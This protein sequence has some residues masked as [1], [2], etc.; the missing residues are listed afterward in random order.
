L[1]ALPSLE[2]TFH[3]LEPVRDPWVLT[4]FRTRW[5]GDGYAH[6]TCDLW[7]DGRLVAVSEQMM[8][9]RPMVVAP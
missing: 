9:V 4:D 8:L 1:R 6:T 2:L 5:H 3:L 7:S